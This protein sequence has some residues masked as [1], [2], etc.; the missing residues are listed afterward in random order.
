MIPLDQVLVDVA[1]VVGGQ[2]LLLSGFVVADVLA[3]RR[4]RRRPRPVAP[5]PAHRPVR[6]LDRRGEHAPRLAAA[7]HRPRPTVPLRRQW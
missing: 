6:V 4:L 7:P 5:L 2:A 3:L 1:V